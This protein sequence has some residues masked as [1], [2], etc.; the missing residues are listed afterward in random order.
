MN[1][2]KREVKAMS[3]NMKLW[4][5]VQ[6]TPEN[7]ISEIKS[8]DGKT[9]NTVAPINRTKKATEMFG[10]YG[11]SWGL[12]KLEHGIERIFD[13]IVLATLDAVFFYKYENKTIEF[14]ISTSLSI[15]HFDGE[16]WKVNHTYRKAIETDLITKALS[17]LGFNADIY[18]DG[19]LVESKDEKSE[20]SKDDLVQFNKTEDESEGR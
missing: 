16:K 19:E 2:T 4:E 17:K 15:M 7:L 6:D 14:E 9:L 11:D 20:L 13:N 8:S 18:T 1:C 10:L 3:E 12:K 5:Q